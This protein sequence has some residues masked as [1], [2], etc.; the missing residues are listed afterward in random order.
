L[1]TA[2]AAAS[3]QGQGR[4]PGIGHA[5]AGN[6]GAI[7]GRNRVRDR[8]LGH[9]RAGRHRGGV[10]ERAMDHLRALGREAKVAVRRHPLVIQKVGLGGRAIGHLDDLGALIELVKH[11]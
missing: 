3:G 4:S 5:G 1:I 10:R 8:G 11:S 6:I 9:A 2:Q 7:Q